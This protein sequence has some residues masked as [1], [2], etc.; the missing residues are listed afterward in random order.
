MQF[1]DMLRILKGQDSNRIKGFLKVALVAIVVV[2]LWENLTEK[3]G[4]QGLTRMSHELLWI[5]PLV[6]ILTVLNWSLE[7]AKWSVLSRPIGFINFWDSFRGVISG[8][9]LSLIVPAGVGECLG[10]LGYMESRKKLEAAALVYLGGV[11]QFLI[12][13][14]FGMFGVY[15]LVRRGISLDVIEF[16]GIILCVATLMGVSVYLMVKHKKL[17]HPGL[18][19]VVSR[20]YQS[21]SIIKVKDLSLFVLFSI[22]RYLVFAFQ[23]YILFK[24]LGIELASEI[25]IAGITWIFLSK[26]I[27]PAINFLSDLGVRE[28]SAIFFFGFYGVEPQLVIMP[29]LILWITNILFPSLLGL[30]F[31]I[32][33]R[34]LSF[35]PQG[36]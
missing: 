22:L 36:S 12:T 23:L 34:I 30:Y 14:I 4:I 1:S 19:R 7:G 33:S 18:V 5:L 11:I 28:L 2:F 20:I 9:T 17:F 10:R 24:A 32:K 21:L 16:S 31:T 35:Q 6:L 25:V 27:L 15:H 8:L 3:E 13:V 26:T 29:T